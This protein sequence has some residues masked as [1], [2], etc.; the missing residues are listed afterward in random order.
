MKFDNWSTSD[1][2]YTDKDY[3]HGYEYIPEVQDTTQIAGTDYYNF[4]TLGISTA[5]IIIEFNR[6]R[7]KFKVVGVYVHGQLISDEY[8]D[9]TKYQILPVNR[10]H[11]MW[12]KYQITWDQ[13][14][15]STLTNIE[16]NCKPAKDEDEWIDI[17]AFVNNDDF[18]ITVIY[19]TE[20]SI[21]ESQYDKNV[22]IPKRY[23][24]KKYKL[25]KTSFLDSYAIELDDCHFVSGSTSDTS[26][27]DNIIEYGHNA[28]WDTIT[29]TSK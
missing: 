22:T 3:G 17:T 11:Y 28:T 14:I 13:N 2:N 26:D 7:T 16:I 23:Q 25:I 10:N 8:K 5:F 18:D 12:N 29:I 9:F 4:T 6:D 24:N 27:N 15:Q 1:P 20:T 21:F 19:N